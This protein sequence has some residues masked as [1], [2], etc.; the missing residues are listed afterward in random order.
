MMM[1]KL[2]L[3]KLL[4]SLAITASPVLAQITVTG[5]TSFGSGTVTLTGTDF[6]GFGA[7][8]IVVIITGEAGNPG[9]QSDG[10]TE[11][12]F[13]GIALTQLVDRNAI[14]RSAPGVNDW[15]QTCNDIWYLDAS[16]FTGGTFPDATTPIAVTSPT[17]GTITVIGL[18]GTQDGAGN[19]AVSERDMNSVDLTTTGGSIVIA[20]Y[21]MGGNGNTASLGGVSWDGQVE[22]SASE[23]GSNWDGHVTGYSN[24]VAAG[25]ATYSFTDSTVAGAHVI[26][27]EFLSGSVAGQLT[28]TDI[29]FDASTD[30]VT[31]TFPK[32]GLPSY[33]VKLS[34]D[35]VSFDTTVGTPIT[36]ASDEN[37]ADVDNITVTLALPTGF[38]GSSKLFFRIEEDISNN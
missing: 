24:D 27:A 4:A 3:L 25:T 12:A 6:N 37:T 7:D 31:L 17:R 16:D 11:V 26:A 30:E 22:V 23:N 28:V 38:E 9:Q 34:S 36:E 2:T 35:L 13:D 15:D 29:Q 10:V 32:T 1:K 33:L 19:T 20:S 5:T 18:S 14:A 8:K 21:G